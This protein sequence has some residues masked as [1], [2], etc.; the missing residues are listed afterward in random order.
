MELLFLL[1]EEENRKVLV[2]VMETLDPRVDLLDGWEV[3]ELV[4]AVVQEDMEKLSVEEMEKLTLEGT[5]MEELMEEVRDK[6]S[7]I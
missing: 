2:V 7:P 1:L 3:L 4:Q 6:V 5:R